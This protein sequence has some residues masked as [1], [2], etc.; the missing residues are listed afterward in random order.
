MAIK[1]K[2]REGETNQA[3]VFRF[4]K[5]IKQSGVLA[6]AR[7][8]QFKDREPNKRK[9]RLSAIYRFKKTKEY[10]RMKK[11]GILK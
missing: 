9:K 6:E 1:V 4:T 3:L 10:E 7:K 8:R 2:K 5:R 11:L